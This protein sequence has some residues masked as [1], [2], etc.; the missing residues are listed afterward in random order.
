MCPPEMLSFHETL[1]KFFRKN[2]LEEVQRL[3]G[4]AYSDVGYS[5]SMTRTSVSNQDQYQRSLSSSRSIDSV[6][7]SRAPYTIPPLELEGPTMM[8]PSLSSLRSSQ[9]ESGNLASPTS[10]ATPR[11]TPL[12]R[13]LAHL[14]RHGMN[15]VSSNSEHNGTV[16][17][18][19]VT[20]PAQSVINVGSTMT[21]AAPS[22]ARSHVG[23][24]SLKG[25]LSRFG[26]LV[27]KR[28]DG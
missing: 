25:R 17:A 15:G 3:F 26:S 12:K 14:A 7:T 21:S 1:E 22:I 11:Q 28:R 20:S 19:S 8:A 16:D 6:S 18:M 27:G 10:P 5:S 2:F 24:A 13:S 23:G 4:D 9:P